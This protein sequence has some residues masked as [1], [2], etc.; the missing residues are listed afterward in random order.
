MIHTM[1]DDNGDF[2]EL[3][4]QPM[5]WLGQMPYVPSYTANVWVAPGGITRTTQQLVAAGANISLRPLW[6]RPWISRMF[7]KH[8][9]ATM[10]QNQILAVVT[11][12]QK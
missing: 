8:T 10:S 3:E 2:E 12:N 9:P 6:V 5:F 1:K 11:R 4:D 7:G